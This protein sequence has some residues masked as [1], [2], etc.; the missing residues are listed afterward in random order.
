VLDADGFVSVSSLPRALARDYITLMDMVSDFGIITCSIQPDPAN[1]EREFS[2]HHIATCFMDLYEFLTS[3]VNDLPQ[4]TEQTAELFSAISFLK[5][6]GLS[7]ALVAKFTTLFAASALTADSLLESVR[8][9]NYLLIFL[10][11]HDDMA[12]AI[13]GNSSGSFLRNINISHLCLSLSERLLYLVSCGRIVSSPYYIELRAL[14]S[15]FRPAGGGAKSHPTAHLQQLLKRIVTVLPEDIC[16]SEFEQS[17]ESVK[18]TISDLD[19]LIRLSVGCLNTEIRDFVAFL[20]SDSESSLRACR[21]PVVATDFLRIPVLPPRVHMIPR[22]SF[23]I[24]RTLLDPAEQAVMIRYF[25]NLEMTRDSFFEVEMDMLQQSEQRSAMR[26]ALDGLKES[27]TALVKRFVAI[28]DSL[29]GLLDNPEVDHETTERDIP[30]SV[31]KSLAVKK[32]QLVALEKHI[33]TITNSLRKAQMLSAQFSAQ[34]EALQRV[35]TVRKYEGKQ[36]SEKGPASPL[37][38]PLQLSREE[39]ADLPPEIRALLHDW[40]TV[41]STAYDE[42]KKGQEKL[43]SLQVHTRVLDDARREIERLRQKSAHMDAVIAKFRIPTDKT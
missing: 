7:S 16:L 11:L 22:P 26:T 18:T 41:T 2:M 33:Q 21:I 32:E 14:G 29:I 42:I 28:R 1:F 6:G 40:V 38:E 10:D 31:F 39:E 27:R 37:T 9:L 23:Q 13:F 30:A 4:Y 34:F 5:R 19:P 36:A 20:D 3:I 15:C 17:L 24:P 25:R 12:S 43:S 35:D 8:I